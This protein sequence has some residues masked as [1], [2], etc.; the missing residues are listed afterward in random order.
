MLKKKP[1]LQ[2]WQEVSPISQH[3]SVW[4][5]AA[6]FICRFVLIA[7]WKGHVNINA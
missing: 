4:I 1:V 5:Y 6:F 7:G 3:N 2:K